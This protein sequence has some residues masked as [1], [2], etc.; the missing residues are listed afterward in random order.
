MENLARLIRDIP[1]FP[2]KGIVF[3]D[4]TPLLRDPSAFAR[5]VDALEARHR[6][7][8]IA[9]VAAVESRGFIFGGALAVR[10]GAGFVP[11]RKPGKLPY[12]TISESYSL[13]YGAGALEVHQDAVRTGDRVLIVDDLL[14]TGGT[15]RA[16]AS[17]ARR[18]GAEVVGASF[19]VELAFLGGRARL[20][21]LPAFS[22][23][24]FD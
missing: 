12:L 18:M 17:L 4:L 5:V 2:T 3:K 23:V 14:A 10:L 11:I 22:L 8:R 1:D 7:D 19:V 6:S 20:E 15:A 9:A 24:R 21:G 13:E 16:A